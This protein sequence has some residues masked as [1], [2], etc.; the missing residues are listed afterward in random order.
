MFSRLTKDFLKPTHQL[1][2]AVILD[3]IF[4][5][6]MVYGSFRLS[7]QKTCI[8]ATDEKFCSFVMPDY[9]QM[10]ICEK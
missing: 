1:S 4:Y 2:Q 6:S 7:L 9:I 5:S 8:H 10:N 3:K